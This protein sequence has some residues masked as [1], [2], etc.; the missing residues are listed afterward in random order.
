MEN[1]LQI[2]KIPL[3]FLGFGC[4]RVENALQIS[5]L[6]LVLHANTYRTSVNFEICQTFKFVFTLLYD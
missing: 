3:V 1:A 5:K 4:R 2:S 6:P